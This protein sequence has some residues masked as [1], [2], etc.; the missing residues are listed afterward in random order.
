MVKTQEE[1]PKVYPHAAVT[2]YKNPWGEVHLRVIRIPK[3]DIEAAQ[4]GR[5]LTYPLP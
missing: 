3:A 5:Q 4:K 1:I 2:E